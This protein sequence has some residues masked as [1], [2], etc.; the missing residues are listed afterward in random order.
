MND[1]TLLVNFAALEEAG[2][3]IQNAVNK[4]DQELGDLDSAA[5]PLVATWSGEAKEAYYRRQKTWTDS[6]NDLK[7]ILQS[8]RHAV[9]EAKGHY[10]DTEKRATNRFA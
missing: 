5:S 7:T 8:I 1:G 6:A 2:Q 3:Q 9:D 10:H 4:L